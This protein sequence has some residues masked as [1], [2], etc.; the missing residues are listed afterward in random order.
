MCEICINRSCSKAEILLKRTDAFGP[1]CFIHAFLSPISKAET[2]KRTLLRT[3]NY[4][5][6]SDKKVTCLS[7]TR[8]NPLSANPTKWSNTLKQF[9]GN[10]RTNYLSVFDHFVKLAL[11]GLNWIFLSAHFCQI[12]QRETFFYTLQQ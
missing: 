11:K 9:V 8:I 7:P 1:V 10:L 4:F 6:P 12:S 5:Q 3:D 2:L